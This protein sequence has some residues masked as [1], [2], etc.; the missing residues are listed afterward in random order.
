VSV[1]SDGNK[2]VGWSAYLLTCTYR[3][4]GDRRSH[5]G[6]IIPSGCCTA[7]DLDKNIGMPVPMGL[8]VAVQQVLDVVRVIGNETVHP[9]ELYLRDDRTTAASL[10]TLVN[11][12][13]EKMIT[14]PRAG[15]EMFDALPQGKRDYVGKRE[16]RKPGA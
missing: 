8:P 16:G 9:A 13:A 12:I 10:F 14:E 6:Q 7:T 15:A 4:C 5:F 2:A 3:A 1:D 11:L